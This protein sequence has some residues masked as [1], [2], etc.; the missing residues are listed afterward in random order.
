MGAFGSFSLGTSTSQADS[1]DKR[2]AIGGPR[3]ENRLKSLITKSSTEDMSPSIKEKSSFGALGRLPEAEPSPV[4]TPWNEGRKTRPGRSDTNPYGDEMPRSGSAALG[5]GRDDSPGYQEQGQSAFSALD[6]K[7]E[8]FG[9]MSGPQF[10]YQER[11][12]TNEPASPTLTNPYASPEFSRVELDRLSNDYPEPSRTSGLNTLREDSP[13]GAFGAFRRDVS[14]QDDRIQNTSTGPN[15]GFPSLSGLGGLGGISSAPWSVGTP[16]KERSGLS[17]GFSEGLFGP[18]SDLQSPTLGGQ[19][20][21]AFFSS[22]NTTGFSRQPK[23]SSMFPPAMQEQMR[24][25]RFRTDRSS[26]EPLRQPDLAFGGLGNRPS[27]GT[28][29]GEAETPHGNTN[30]LF[31]D[32]GTTDAS[33]RPNRGLEDNMP[34]SQ[35]SQPFGSPPGNVFSSAPGSGPGSRVAAAPESATP[36]GSGFARPSESPSNQLPPAQQ[37]QM[38]MPDRMLWI[39]RDP[40]GNTQGPWSGLEMHDWFKAGF[41]TAELQVKKLEDADFEPLAQLVRR[42]GN[43]REPFLVPQIGVPHG[44]V[45]SSQPSQWPSSTTTAGPPTQAGPTQPPFANSFPSFGTTL[46]AEQQNALE[47]RKQEEQFLMARQKEHLAQQQVIMKQMQLQGGPHGMQQSL[48]HQ[49]SAHSLHSQPSFGSITS[50][51]GYQASPSSGPLPPPGSGF[52]EGHARH[53]PGQNVGPGMPSQSFPNFRDEDLPGFMERL[54]MR[55]APQAPIGPDSYN[56][57]NPNPQIIGAMFNDRARLQAEQQAYDARTQKDSF[58][59]RDSQERLRQFQTLRDFPDDEGQFRDISQRVTQ[60]PPNAADFEAQSHGQWNR[61]AIGAAVGEQSGLIGVDLKERQDGT[62]RSNESQ[63]DSDETWVKVDTT[64]SSQQPPRHTIS[65]LPAPAA[66][67]NR[68][69]VADNLVAET[70]SQLQTP[71]ETPTTSLA[72]WAEKFSEPAKGPSLKEIQEAEARKAAREEEVAAAAARRAQAEIEKQAAPPAPAPGLPQSSTWGN[73]SSATANTPSASVWSKPTTGKA[74][75]AVPVAA[76]K[77]TLAQIQKEEET[78][79]Q[80]A[81]AAAAAANAQ[82][83]AANPVAQ[84]KRYADLA[85]KIAPP[86]QAWTTVGSGGKVKPPPTVVATPQISSRSLSGHTTPSGTVSKSRPNAQ[87]A[88]STAA[89]AMPLNQSKAN[90]EF[91]KWAKGS[92]GRGL[93]S[94]INGKGMSHTS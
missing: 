56:S 2:S 21:S 44:P 14:G 39:Y 7:P 61:G 43:S 4:Q 15:R 88:R 41:F 38:V 3:G 10:T 11:Q 92:L 33:I 75:T 49:T 51:Q 58:Q 93:N 82:T 45:S 24:N 70:L 80:R 79:K 59:N 20:G 26:D 47:R 52:L 90:E 84:G 77:K 81:A 48:Q 57:Q 69:H 40:T 63:E 31:S 54:T 87:T 91:S 13:L 35:T 30:S 8:T 25:D 19:G 32:F 37:R 74:T 5:G 65:P 68:Q 86:S 85:S 83:S 34:F 78:R 55:G 1:A 72:P 89:A 76:T 27:Q 9:D 18:M 46:T 50:P 16:A 42:I 67:R 53:H 17:S 36:G 71:I 12:Y 28:F 64:E 73:T 60:P 29:K 94:G 22:P 62:D 66:Q 23:M 6:T